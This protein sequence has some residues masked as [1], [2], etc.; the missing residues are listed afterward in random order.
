MLQ[1]LLS[2]PGRAV[3]AKFGG[4]GPSIF[5]SK[6]AGNWRNLVVEIKGSKMTGLDQSSRASVIQKNLNRRPRREQLVRHEDSPDYGG[7]SSQGPGR[8]EE[9][10]PTS[11][12][13]EKQGVVKG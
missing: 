11:V 12:C 6:I 4:H 5:F 10:Q 1:L 8:W 13:A 3:H 9:L 2:C 7:N